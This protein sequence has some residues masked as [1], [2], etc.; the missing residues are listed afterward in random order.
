[1]AWYIDSSVI[2]AIRCLYPEFI[3][4]S[5]AIE[6]LRLM[7]TTPFRHRIITNTVPVRVLLGGS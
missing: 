2:P 4:A 5:V 6:K 7:Q 1:M 3:A